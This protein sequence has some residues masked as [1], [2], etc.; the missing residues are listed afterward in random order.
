MSRENLSR[1]KEAQ[2]KCKE[3]LRASMEVGVHLLKLRDL[4]YNKSSAYQY[5]EDN[6]AHRIE[7]LYVTMGTIIKECEG[8]VNSIDDYEYQIHDASNV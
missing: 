5:S 4:I 2:A 1:L 8:L 6:A 3:D 7:A